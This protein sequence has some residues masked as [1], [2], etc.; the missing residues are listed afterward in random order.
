[1]IKFVSL[2]RSKDFQ[3]ILGEN[4]FNTNYFTMFYGKSLNN[5]KKKMNKLYISFV[6]KKKIGNAVKRNKIKRRLKFAVQK[7]LKNK[8]KVNFD[9]TYVILAKSKIF[10]DEFSKTFNQIKNAFEKAKC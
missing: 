7:L 2:K 3:T 4:R 9:F 6:A 10:D 1:M 8:N 5:S